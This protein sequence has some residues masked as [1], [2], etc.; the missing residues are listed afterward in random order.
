M[1]ANDNGNVPVNSNLNVPI[2][3][4][5][6]PANSTS[7]GVSPEAGASALPNNNSAPPMSPRVKKKGGGQPYKVK[8]T[9]FWGWLRGFFVPDYDIPEEELEE[10]RMLS[11]LEPLEICRLRQYFEDEVGSKDGYMTKEMFLD[12]PFV[13]GNPLKERLALCF[14][15]DA[16][17][18]K[19]DF[20]TWLQGVALFNSHGKKEEKLKLAFK[21]QDFDGDG[22]LSKE[23]LT[24]Y[25][26]LITGFG[27]QIKG[28]KL[29]TVNEFQL[30]D[31]VE[32]C[33]RES[34]TDNK[35]Q[36]ISFQDF[37]RVMAPTDFHI[38]LVLPF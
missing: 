19:M 24:K 22:M 7:S 29:L 32:E 8:Y 30:R 1:A 34:S 14:G 20:V 23:D 9:T 25:L 27:N 17:T 15:Y 16:E 4:G 28:A 3:A 2:D 26:Q 35:M 38:K 10:Y 36:Y 5:S 18:Q 33:F 6:A 11:G 31:V 13:S 12:I 37:S 21:L